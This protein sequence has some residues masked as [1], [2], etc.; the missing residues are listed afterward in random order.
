M[1]RA[2]AFG[3]P[4]HPMLVAFPIGLLV[5]AAGFDV[6]YLARGS[7]E[8]ARVSYWMIATGIAGGLAAAIFGVRDWLAIPDVSRAKRIGLRHGIA[9]LTAILLFGA[10]W[11]MRNDDPMRLPSMTALACSF[12]GLATLAVTGWLGGSLVFRHGIGVDMR[13]GGRAV[14]TEHGEPRRPGSTG[15]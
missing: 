3:H 6:A 5:T 12:L 9:S 4:I 1:S 14:T 7:E 8:L 15:H 11:M 10:S 2:V 13:A